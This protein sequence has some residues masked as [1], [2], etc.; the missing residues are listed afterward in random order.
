MDISPGYGNISTANGSTK[1]RNATT[2]I[3]SLSENL[4][5]F[6]RYETMDGTSPRLNTAR[7]PGF[8]LTIAG[9]QGLKTVQQLGNTTIHRTTTSL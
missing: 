9:V 1:K 7:V 3:A 5:L 6:N 4:L 2:T 8:Q